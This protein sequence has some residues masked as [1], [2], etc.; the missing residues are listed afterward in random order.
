MIIVCF[1]SGFGRG[2]CFLLSGLGRALDGVLA[3]V[4]GGGFGYWL[5]GLDG[6]SF[7]CYNGP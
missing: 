3:F 4:G 7:L 1:G 6:T 5:L 2:L